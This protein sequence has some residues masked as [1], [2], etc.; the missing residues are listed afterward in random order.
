VSP[1]LLQPLKLCPHIA[2]IL[3][4]RSPTHLAIDKPV[5]A[6]PPPSMAAAMGASPLPHV[7]LPA[8]DLADPLSWA[9]LE[10]RSE[11]ARLHSNL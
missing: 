1:F 11:A 5:A 7:G 2:G 4:D 6:G 9:R 8:R 3:L 10:A